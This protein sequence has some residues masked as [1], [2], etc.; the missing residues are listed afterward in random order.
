[1]NEMKQRTE[2]DLNRAKASLQRANEEGDAEAQVAATTDLAS[3][4][5]EQKMAGSY[6]PQTQMTPEQHEMALRQRV[7][8]QAPPAP[9]PKLQEWQGNNQWFGTDPDMTMVAQSKHRQLTEQQNVSPHTEQYWNEIDKHMRSTFPHKFEKPAGNSGNGISEPERTSRT[10]SIVSPV[11][12]ESGGTGG[13]NR[14]LLTQSQVNLAKKFGL[15]TKQYAAQV[16]KLQEQGQ[17]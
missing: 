9:D 7:A 17:A 5:V 12:R 13:G 14:I 3:A 1:M 16:A 4:Q 15:T 8:Q 10:T 2:A 6:Q 11:N